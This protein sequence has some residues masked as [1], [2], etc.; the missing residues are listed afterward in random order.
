[1]SCVMLVDAHI[2]TTIITTT[3]SSKTA[4]FMV[5]GSRL[6]LP[7]TDDI[8]TKMEGRGGFA[9]QN[10]ITVIVR[11]QMFKYLQDDSFAIV[12]CT[13]GGGA[14]SLHANMH[15]PC[16]IKICRTYCGE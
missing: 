5:F 14:I 16:I 7:S 9:T 8:I 3:T 2:T 10:Y 12:M 13:S 1:M 15:K 4:R 11:V 6:L